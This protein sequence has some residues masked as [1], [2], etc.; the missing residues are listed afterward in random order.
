MVMGKFD[1]ETFLGG[2]LIFFLGGRGGKRKNQG[3]VSMV[4]RWTTRV[5]KQPHFVLY[6]ILSSGSFASVC[7]QAIANGVPDPRCPGQTGVL[8]RLRQPTTYSTHLRRWRDCCSSFRHGL[9]GAVGMMF[10]Y[11]RSMLIYVICLLHVYV[12]YMLL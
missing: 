6:F 1:G 9:H 10:M 3:T 8:F 7:L 2:L 5:F 4:G 11:M 12:C